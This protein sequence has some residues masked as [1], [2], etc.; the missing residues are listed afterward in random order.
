MLLI[1]FIIA[2]VIIFG[3][4][5][6]V[7]KKMIFQDTS[8]A[9]NRLTKLDDMNRQKE[10]QLAVKLEETEK[11]L[12][13]K[14]QELVEEEK[15][16]K[17]ESERAANQLYD[18]IVGKAKKEAE[19]V[20]KKAIA[21]RDKMKMDSMIEA[22]EKVIDI[23]RE[24]LAKIM[25]SVIDQALNESLVNNFFKDL[26][27]ADM[28]V[29]NKNVD[30]AEIVSAKPVSEE[31]VKRAKEV[32]SKKLERNI[33]VKSSVDANLIGGVLMKFGTLV[34]DDSLSERLKEMAVELKSGLT[35][36]YKTV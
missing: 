20:V 16:M 14:R 17:M 26:E 19:E 5:I 35:S 36:K 25:S 13:Q 8:S 10:K 22:E 23:C 4:I 3:I 29:I 1:G 12:D 24:I 2:Q 15:K 9:I 32:L 7:L 11:L 6:F 21:A 28:S 18:D 34:V 31:L 30:R 33:E 27:T